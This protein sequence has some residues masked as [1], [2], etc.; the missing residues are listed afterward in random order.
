MTKIARAAGYGLI[1]KARD[2]D[3]ERKIFTEPMTALNYLPPNKF[4]VRHVKFI[5]TGDYKPG[6]RGHMDVWGEW[7]EYPARIENP[8]THRICQ[9]ED[10]EM[11]LWI[12]EAP[13]FKRGTWIEARYLKKVE[14][15]PE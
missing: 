3:A 1:D 13:N 9:I 7:D 4:T 12:D 5:Q 10:D 14:K 6:M 11:N 8:I 15:C 2:N